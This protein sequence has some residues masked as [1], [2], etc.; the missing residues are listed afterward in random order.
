MIYNIFHRTIYAYTAPV[1]SFLPNGFG[2]YDM[3]GNVWSWAEDCYHDSAAGAP[4]DGV[5]WTTGN[6]SSRVIRGGAWADPPEFLRAAFRNSS[7]T[8]LRDYSGGF[9]LARTLLTP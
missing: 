6:C 1:G 3:H 4:S 2:L 5:A 8:E 9:R 7:P